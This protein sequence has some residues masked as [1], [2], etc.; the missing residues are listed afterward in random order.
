MARPPAAAA[1]ITAAASATSA[2]QATN[3]GVTPATA[4]SG[5]ASRTCGQAFASALAADPAVTGWPR[6]GA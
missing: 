1:R 4:S 6:G 3:R 2:G 5:P